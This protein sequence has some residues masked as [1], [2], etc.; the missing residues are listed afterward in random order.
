VRTRGRLLRRVHDLTEGTEFAAGSEVACH[1]N[2][3][4]PNFVFRDTSP[5]AVIDWDGTEPASA[6]RTSATSSGRS[7]IPRSTAKARRPP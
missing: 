4:Q 2:L 7:S 1:P 3:S 5:V 6:G